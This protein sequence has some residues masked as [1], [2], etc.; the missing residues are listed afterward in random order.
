MGVEKITQ[1]EWEEKI[2]T[3]RVV[4]DCYADWCGPCRMLSPIVDEIANEVENV[5]FYKLN[6][7]EAEELA[8]RYRIMSIP[9]LL[10]FE[11]GELK[12]TMIGLR[13]KEEIKAELE[14]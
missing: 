8:K 6:V 9:T 4:I 1:R 2:K 14:K 13:S 12:T 7:D 10:F 11:N 5:T 3:G